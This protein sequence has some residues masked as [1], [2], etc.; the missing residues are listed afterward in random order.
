MSS[1]TVTFALVDPSLALIN[2]MAA[3]CRRHGHLGVQI[4]ASESAKSE[5]P[6]RKQERKFVSTSPRSQVPDKFA[7]S[8]SGE[9]PKV[10]VTGTK[11]KI[12]KAPVVAAPAVSNAERKKR[13]RARRSA[14][15][16]VV[17]AV[18]DLTSHP[19]YVRTVGN[20]SFKSSMPYGITDFHLVDDPPALG[21]LSKA[22]PLS[23][24]RQFVLSL[25]I[26][27]SKYNANFVLVVEHKACFHVILFPGA[28]AELRAQVDK[29]STLDPVEAK[30]LA[31]T[32]FWDEWT[33][34]TDVHQILPKV[35][36][37]TLPE[38]SD[39]EGESVDDQE[40]V[41]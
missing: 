10:V 12:L 13:A 17:N 2:E 38:E 5:K 25:G 4:V 35:Y 20:T 23:A 14:E 27:A 33:S 9:K 16:G 34:I 11:K 6:R 1:T 19:N 32:D 29:K 24:F 26:P 28:S 7:P 21:E 41:D 18:A 40:V 31:V 22:E 36:L 15:K 8:T 3:L 37:D 30:A 39:G